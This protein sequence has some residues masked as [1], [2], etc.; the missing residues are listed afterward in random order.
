MYNFDLGMYK[1]MYSNYV[2]CTC[3]LYSVLSM[4]NTVHVICM[5]M[6]SVHV[7]VCIVLICNVHIY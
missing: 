1:Y 2:H 6:Y 7:Q 4:C 5:Y 3:T